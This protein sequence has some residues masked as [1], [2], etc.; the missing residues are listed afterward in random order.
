M[1]RSPLLGATAVASLLLVGTACSGED[2]PSA[3]DIKEELSAT[4]Q[5]GSDGLSEDQADCFADLIIDEAGIEELKDVDLSADVPPEE[6]QDA[7]AAATVRAIDECDL[8]PGG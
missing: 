8:T 4:F 3:A 2:E 1:R 7:V 5:Q 6:I